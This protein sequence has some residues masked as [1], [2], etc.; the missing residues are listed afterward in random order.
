MWVC[1]VAAAEGRTGGRS[2][3]PSGMVGGGG[4]AG[5]GAQAAQQLPLSKASTP[6]STPSTA[7][8]PPTPPP[9]TPAQPTSPHTHHPQP[10]THPHDDARQRGHQ[11]LQLEEQRLLEGVLGGPHLQHILAHHAAQRAGRGRAKGKGVGVA[12]SLAPPASSCVRLPPACSPSLPTPGPHPHT[13]PPPCPPDV[14]WLELELG[15]RHQRAPHLPRP[16]AQLQV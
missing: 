3:L 13:T 2:A 16:D 7:H 5:G 12:G 14:I 11:V 9:S 4:G 6:A 8:L 15:R 1:E 10:P